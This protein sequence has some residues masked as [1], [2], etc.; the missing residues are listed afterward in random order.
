MEVLEGYVFL[1][2]FLSFHF[3]QLLLFLLSNNML[4]FDHALELQPLCL[5]HV[6]LCRTCCVTFGLSLACI[7]RDVLIVVAYT[8]LCGMVYVRR[9]YG[10]VHRGRGR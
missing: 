3:V 4:L 5:L 10:Q 2:I 9:S 8:S 1:N 6:T 7:R